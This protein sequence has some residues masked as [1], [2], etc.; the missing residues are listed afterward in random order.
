MVDRIEDREQLARLVAVAEGGEREHRP[1]RRVRVLAAVLADAGQVALDVAG[2]E[3]GVVERG[4]EE[5]HQAVAAPDEVLVDCGHRP[6]RPRS[7]GGAR[8]NAP[9]LGDRVDAALRRCSPSRA[10]CRRRR[11]R[12]DTSRR[13]S[14]APRARRAG[15]R[16]CARQRSARAASARDSAI[17][18]KAASVRYR[19]Q[20]SQTLSPWPFSP[21]RFMPSFQSP[22]PISGSP[23]APTP[24]LQSIAAAQCSYSV[25]RR[26]DCSGWK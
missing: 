20:P 13:P 10:V 5:Q 8:Q 15:A 26:D 17:G 22:V 18:T 9:R 3:V 14:R 6:L 4:R 7:V 11:R 21:T 16:M 12:A 24:R 19:N 1:D 23:W 25:P 2:V